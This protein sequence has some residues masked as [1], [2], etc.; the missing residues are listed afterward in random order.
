MTIFMRISDILN[1]ICEKIVI[2]TIGGYIVVMFVQVIL[3]NFLPQYAF[4]WA[5]GVCRYLFIW[6]VFIGAAVAAKR[7]GHIAVTLLPDILKKKKA[8]SYAIIVG[9]I[10]LCFL[11]IMFITTYTGLILVEVGLIQ[12]SDSLPISVSWVYAALPLGGV[13]V[14][15]QL[16]VTALSDFLTK[17]ASE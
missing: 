6:S 15:Y 16:F 1:K 8:K 9:I 13:I 11:A 3:R 17:E 7:K 14:I 10:T 5:D 4:P 12:Q 2:A